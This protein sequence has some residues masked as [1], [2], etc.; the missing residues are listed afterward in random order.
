MITPTCRDGFHTPRGHGKHGRLKYLVVP[1]KAGTHSSAVRDVDGWVPAFAGTTSL[2]DELH[3][4]SARNKPRTVASGSAA[5][6]ISPITATPLAPAA[7]QAAALVSSI[8]AKA[9]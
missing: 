1:A 4:L 8:P 6:M 7:R 9:M 2:F 5:R 3:H